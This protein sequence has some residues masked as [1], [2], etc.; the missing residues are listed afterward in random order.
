MVLLFTDR[1]DYIIVIQH[2]FIHSQF[3]EFFGKNTFNT[4][5]GLHL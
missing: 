1:H 4:F 3:K 2:S 5:M